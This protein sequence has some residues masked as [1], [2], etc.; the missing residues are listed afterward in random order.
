MNCEWRIEYEAKALRQLKKLDAQQATRI[1]E[2]LRDNLEKYEEPRAF[3]EAM[4]GDWTGFWRYRI[5]DY[6][7]ICKIEDDVVTVFVIEV[8]HRSDIY[9]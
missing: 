9:R 5:G 3:G 7:A 1:V 6:R 8:G 2:T 4:A